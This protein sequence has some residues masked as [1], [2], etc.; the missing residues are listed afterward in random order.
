[1]P[2]KAT[3]RGPD[4]RFSSQARAEIQLTSR[5]GRGPSEGS[6]AAV[7]VRLATYTRRHPLVKDHVTLGIT[8]FGDVGP[9]HRVAGFLL[10]A[11]TGQGSTHAFIADAIRWC[12]DPHPEED[13]V[14]NCSP[15]VLA[16]IPL[17]PIML[18]ASDLPVNLLLGDFFT[19]VTLP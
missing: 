1:M 12:S 17:T 6:R 9:A 11:F 18:G 19:P 14:R 7:V 4:S 5:R 3:P 13:A 8:A 16:A 2:V 10:S 15:Q